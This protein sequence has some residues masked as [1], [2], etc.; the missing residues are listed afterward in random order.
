MRHG[1]RRAAFHFQRRHGKALAMLVMAGVAY[2]VSRWQTPRDSVDP[3][4]LEEGNYRVERVVDGDTLLLAEHTRVRLIGV[5]TPESVKPNTPVQPWALEASAFTK[6]FVGDGP[7]RLQFDRERT[8][9]YGR[10]LAYVWVDQQMLNEELIR[11]G[12]AKWEPNYHYS[13]AM[14]AR[15]RAAQQEA[16]TARRGLWSTA[17]PPSVGAGK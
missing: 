12:L 11:A 1:G 2:L 3:H 13:A 8:D 6:R 17:P 7:V 5:D 14:K 15:F 4:G 10:L 16:Q 9:K